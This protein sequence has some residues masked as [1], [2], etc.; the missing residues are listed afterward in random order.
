MPSLQLSRIVI[1]S[2]ASVTQAVPRPTR[3]GQVLV[4]PEPT[5]PT[6]TGVLAE[7]GDSGPASCALA[8]SARHPDGQ[9]FVCVIDAAGVTML[10]ADWF[11]G[12]LAIKGSALVVTTVAGLLARRTSDIA[13]S[14]DVTV[15]SRP[16]GG[17]RRVLPVVRVD[18]PRRRTTCG[19]TSPGSPTCQQRTPVGGKTVESSNGSSLGALQMTRVPRSLLAL[20]AALALAA[21][22]SVVVFRPWMEVDL[23]LA[24]LVVCGLVSA[25][26]AIV[27]RLPSGGAAE[28]L[29]SI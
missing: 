3:S 29:V 2:P 6:S 4:A 5:P 27:G 18:F 23:L 25:A 11:A 20:L 26:L 19:Q 8:V 28:G 13:R 17:S 1:Q 10:A 14:V 22:A 16:L 21:A 7:A 15:A 24:A 12:H 9:L